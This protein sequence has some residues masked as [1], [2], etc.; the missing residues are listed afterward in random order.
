[1]KSCVKRKQGSWLAAG[2]ETGFFSFSDSWEGVKIWKRN[3]IYQT[4]IEKIIF[5]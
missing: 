3:K 1:M 2:G 4:V 5:V